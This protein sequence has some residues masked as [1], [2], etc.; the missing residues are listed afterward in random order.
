MGEMP[1][2]LEVAAA[3]W[4]LTRELLLF[5]ALGIAISGLDELFVD[6]VYWAD[7]LKR[8]LTVYRHHERWTA[9]RIPAS[10]DQ[11]RMAIFVP[12]W[13]EAQVIG[14]ML[15]GLLARLDYADYDVFVGVYPNDEMTVHAVSEVLDGPGGGRV[16]MVVGDEPGPTT[17]AACLNTLWLAMIAEEARRQR[18]YKA[19]ILHDAEDIV[20]SAELKLFDYLIPRK[21]MVQL[22]VYPLV[23]RDSPWIS[24]HYLDE[25]AEHHGKNLVVRERL[26]AALP[27]AGV[28]C[29]FERKR[30]GDLANERGGIPFTP[31]ALTEDYELGLQMSAGGR[32]AFVRLPGDSDRRFVSTREHF[33][34]TM[35]AA[36]R[37]KTRWL[38]GIAFQGW[39]SF[40]WKGGLAEK[41]MLLRDR[42]ALANAFLILIGYVAALFVAIAIAALWL[43]PELSVMP[44]LVQP[45]SF[46]AKLLVFTA[47]LLGWRLLMRF[48]FTWRAYGL[49]QGLLSIPRNIVGNVIG[50]LSARRA[51]AGYVKLRLGRGD[52][53]WQKTSHRFPE[54]MPA[55]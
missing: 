29:A 41:Y 39:D 42:K 19:I 38:L 51:L 55:E 48:W 47:I 11:G 54:R 7:R 30:L 24:G 27:S 5:A 12:A 9:A 23:D 37:Q 36:L 52:L 43:L 50:I 40:G 18:Q 13:D 26:G 45:D 8:R 28:A 14:A 22:P 2:I 25:F 46:L 32:G 35:E 33:P 6:A 15:R 16:R 31:G 4:L 10:A 1:F 44:A 17:K 3:F 49:A 20:H 53:R 34:D 21:T